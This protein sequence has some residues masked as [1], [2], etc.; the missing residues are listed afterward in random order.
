MAT[1]FPCA[2]CRAG[3]CARGDGG[4][5]PVCGTPGD[6]ED[7]DDGLGYAIGYR[8][9][10]PCTGGAVTTATRMDRHDRLFDRFEDEVEDLFAVGHSLVTVEWDTI[11]GE[12]EFSHFVLALREDRPRAAKV[13]R[14]SPA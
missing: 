14:L 3:T 7:G 6:A 8:L 11:H 9:T 4:F 2:N 5:C 1:D 13:W 12:T 10:L